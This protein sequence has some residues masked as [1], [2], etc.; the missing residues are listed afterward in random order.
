MKRNLDRRN[1]LRTTGMT[2]T[3]AMTSA[4]TADGGAL[5]AAENKPNA[6]STPSAAKLGWPVS[7]ATYTFRGVSF[8]EALD[9]IAALGVQN[10]EP[11]FFLR[12]DSKRPNL[13]TGETLSTELRKEM[14]Q[15]IADHG[16]A[17]R[18]YYAN[19]TADAD[20]ARRVFEFAKEMGALTIV[21]EPPAA[22]FDMVEK[23]CDEYQ[24]NLAVH[25]HPK[26]P[27][28][29]YWNPDAV[30]AVCHG[31]GKRIGACCDTG[32]WIRSGMNVIECIKKMQGRIISMHLKDVAQSGKPA[33]RDVPLG[34]G[35]ADY[36]GVLRE[37]KRQGFKGIMTVEYEHESPQLMDDVAQCL[38]FV[39]KMARKL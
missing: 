6:L 15:R 12:L 38:A 27:K 34:Q 26:S 5:R 17:M 4:W 2:I 30:L 7:I 28:S 25:N 11:A 13:K 1:F 14:K 18:S 20:A 33:A 24:I 31:R 36:A 9:K 32:H 21:A 39:E 22:A 3:A 37:L 29:H 10:V 8:Y 19:V 23:L 16:I 35:L